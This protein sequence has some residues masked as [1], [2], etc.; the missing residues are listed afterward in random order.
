MGS[1]G[2]SSGYWE[3]KDLI[4]KG[5][6][7]FQVESIGIGNQNFHDGDSGSTKINVIGS[8]SHVLSTI[9]VNGGGFGYLIT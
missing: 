8:R 4:L 2:G 5:A 1:C 6:V 7:T 3:I 9:S